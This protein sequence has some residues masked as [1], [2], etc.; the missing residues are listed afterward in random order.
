MWVFCLVLKMIIASVRLPALG[1]CHVSDTGTCVG[2]VVSALCGVYLDL[3][4]QPCIAA[5]LRVHYVYKLIVS[6]RPPF[7][8]RAQLRTTRHVCHL[9]SGHKAAHYGQTGFSD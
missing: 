7:S 2:V 1:S 9:L 8:Q 5:L 6:L 4:A 3:H